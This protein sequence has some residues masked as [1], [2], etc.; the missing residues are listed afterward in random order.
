MWDTRRKWDLERRANE[1]MYH[2]RPPSASSS[3]HTPTQGFLRRRIGL[4]RAKM[5]RW[6]AKFDSAIKLHFR[7]PIYTRRQTLSYNV[8][9]RYIL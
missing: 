9:P 5:P 7:K 1:Q 6:Q 4:R 8:T 2:R 3:S